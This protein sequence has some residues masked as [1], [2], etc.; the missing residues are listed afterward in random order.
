MRAFL[1]FGD[2]QTATRTDGVLEGT[3]NVD[4]FAAA[5]FV[6]H[7]DRVIRGVRSEESARGEA[8]EAVCCFT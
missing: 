2:R 8:I 3:I 4:A 5:A 6:V 1:N 7:L